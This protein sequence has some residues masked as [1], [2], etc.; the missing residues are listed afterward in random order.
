MT[1]LLERL[2][3]LKTARNWLGMLAQAEATSKLARIS[4]YYLQQYPSEAQID[5]RLADFDGYQLLFSVWLIA[6]VRILIDDVLELPS[7]RF[8][9][10]KQ[11]WIDEAQRVSRHFPRSEDLHD[12]MRSPRHSR[13]WGDFYLYRPSR[14]TELLNIDKQ[15]LWL[16]KAAARR[17]ALRR[18][19]AL[20]GSLERDP[21]LP[22][23]GL[24]HARQ[25]LATLPSQ[26]ELGRRFDGLNGRRFHE[27]LEAL[28]Q[29]CQLVEA[30][31]DG[32]FPC[33]ARQRVRVQTVARHLPFSDYFPLHGIDPRQRGPWLRWLFLAKPAQR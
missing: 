5:R 8:P 16:G 1:T 11:A 32:T 7:T 13:A 24:S 28:E 2:S 19:P 10:V 21:N 26:G 25:V 23:L 30:V 33:S 18:L 17:E 20:I 15:Q 4:R 31:V 12:V 29:G 3:A 27:I 6:H 9:E 14:Q 22:P